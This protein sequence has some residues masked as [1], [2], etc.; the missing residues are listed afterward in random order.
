MMYL[1]SSLTISSGIIAKALSS[2][3]SLF[4]F[5]ILSR[6]SWE[7]ENFSNVEEVDAGAVADE[8]EDVV[9]AVDEIV[10]DDDAED[11]DRP[12][13]FIDGVAAVGG[14]AARL[15]SSNGNLIRSKIE[16]IEFNGVN[17]NERP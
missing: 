5:A 16:P 11:D 12:S 8:V 14:F 2:D 15:E 13:G 6:I 7:A 4:E 17:W 10:V 1:S 9:E 3:P